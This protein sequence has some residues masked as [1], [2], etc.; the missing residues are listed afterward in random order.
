MEAM[1]TQDE[2][3]DYMGFGKPTT[4][5]ASD[6]PNSY[7]IKEAYVDIKEEENE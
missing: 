2:I 5:K 1:K 7:E 4:E 6:N 3:F